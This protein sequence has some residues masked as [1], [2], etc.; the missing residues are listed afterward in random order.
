[1]PLSFLKSKKTSW[2]HL[3]WCHLS[4]PRLVI[5]EAAWPRRLASAEFSSV[6][7]ES[8]SAT[9]GFGFNSWKMKKPC[10]SVVSPPSRSVGH[11]SCCCWGS[12]GPERSVTGM[13]AQQMAW[14]FGAASEDLR[15][16]IPGNCATGE[17]WGRD[18][19][20]Q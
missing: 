14:N 6:G 5:S 2:T 17:K 8:S 11:I 7:P 10:C 19:E 1:M 16:S 20:S 12:V 9:Q 3:L 15:S 13:L 18:E 4:L